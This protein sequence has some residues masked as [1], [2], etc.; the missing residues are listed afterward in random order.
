VDGQAAID[1]E[2]PRSIPELI[3]ASCGLYLRVPVLFLVL[4]AVVVVPYEFAVLLI[5]GDGPLALGHDGFFTSQLVM[6]A[7][8]FL[9]TPLISALHVHAVREVG[10]GGRPRLFP[11]FRRSLSTLPVVD[12]RRASAGSGSCSAASPSPFQA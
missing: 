8:T 10:D 3:G 2:R 12:W 6:L 7:D 4:A 1:L 9:A 11:T 5:T